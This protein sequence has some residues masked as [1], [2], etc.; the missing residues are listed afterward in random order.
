M[1]TSLDCDDKNVVQM[2]P[3]LTKFLPYYKYYIVDAVL[4]HPIG[5]FMVYGLKN[6]HINPIKDPG[7][8]ACENNMLIHD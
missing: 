3:S 1:F 6:W 7:I 5:W 2:C 4:S 8:A